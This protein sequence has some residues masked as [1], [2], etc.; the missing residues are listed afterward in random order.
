MIDVNVNNIINEVDVNVTTD[1]SN[2][3]FVVNNNV[4]EVDV[5]LTTDEINID[6]TVNNTINEVDV[7]VSVEE[8]NIDFTVN[9]EST[10][11][12]VVVNPEIAAN[13]GDKGDQG[14]QGVQGVQG[15]KGD[16]GSNGQGVPLAGEKNQIL[17]KNSSTNFDTSFKYGWF[18]YLTNVKYTNN[19]TSVTGGT[20]RE[21]TLRG[22]IV[23]RYTT[24]SFVGLYPSTD[25]FYSSFDGVN[26]T[27]KIVGKG[28]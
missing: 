5:N 1:E 11:I 13:K 3:D 21:A 20:V 4:N 28:D 25:S 22:D 16:D 10:D 17:V 6:F 24:D 8:T 27:N 18:D 15:E 14:I 9:V 2:V 26:V 12:E 19:N 23:Y 7:S